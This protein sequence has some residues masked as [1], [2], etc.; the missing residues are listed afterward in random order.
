MAP[1]FAMGSNRHLFLNRNDQAGPS[2]LTAS[3][4]SPPMELGMK[5]G[6]SRCSAVA[7]AATRRENYS[8][9]G[10]SAS[11]RLRCAVPGWPRASETGALHVRRKTAG[12]MGDSWADKTWLQRLS[13]DQLRV[14]CWSYRFMSPNLIGASVCDTVAKPPKKQAGGTTA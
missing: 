7:L 12:C 13:L 2:W 11:T 4:L 1:F 5:P 14:L 10:E 8:V 3:S 6:H 9:M